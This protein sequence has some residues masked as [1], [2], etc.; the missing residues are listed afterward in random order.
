MPVTGHTAS[1][2]RAVDHANRPLAIATFISALV[3]LLSGVLTYRA[4]R[5]N[6]EANGW[7]AHTYEVIAH[8]EAVR[9]TVTSAETAERAY[10][11]VGDPAQLASFRH[12]KRQIPARLAELRRLTSDNPAQQARLDSLQRAVAIR[13]ASLD[14]AIAMQSS[15]DPAGAVA[16]VRNSG[17]RL[18][19][20]VRTE[21]SAMRDAEQRLLK[22]RVAQARSATQLGA[23]ATFGTS[24]LATALLA[25]LYL[26]S[27]RH[28]SRLAREQRE[29]LDSREQTRAKAMELQA[30]N[31]QLQH[32]AE[33]LEQRV[34]ERTAALGEANAELEGFA[35]TV[36][37]DLRAPLR[38]IQGY[39]T[40][41]LEDEA[42]RMSADGQDYTNR[43]AASAGRLDGMITDLLAYSRMARASLHLERVDPAAVVDEVLQD[44]VADIESTRATVEV[45]GPLP[46]VLAHRA[47]LA[48]VLANLLSNAFKFV[49]PG[50]A[51]YVAVEAT[52]QGDM[53]ILSVTDRGIGIAA[54]H[55]E[56]IF[57][58]FER[59]HGQEQYP[60]TGIGL[61]I[62]RKGVERMGGQI[63]V[64]SP[65][66]RGGSRFEIRLPAA[67]ASP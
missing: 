37:H 42:P 23:G 39:A 3:L 38:N 16:I 43:L 65:F 56:R 5:A 7:V 28:A 41:L 20:Q 30:A 36:A 49:L 17:L 47:T 4:L 21:F 57:D 26:L 10:L 2:A 32:A 29:L 13:L 54:E 31:A 11:L 35:R 9:A 64:H 50:D 22:I 59:L 60:G 15:G 8:L 27:S 46:A 1:L 18:M 25:A 6:D 66:G 52:R 48:Q 12:F 40:A 55:H 19:E 51:P 14:R 58:V 62:V 67:G 53:V 33:V 63:T 34:S 45:A 61:A 44:L 24:I